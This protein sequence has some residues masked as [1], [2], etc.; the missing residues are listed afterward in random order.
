V[1][2]AGRPHSRRARASWAGPVPV[3]SLRFLG[4]PTLRVPAPAP[5][6]APAGARAL[7]EESGGSAGRRGGPPPPAPSASPLSAS[8]GWICVGGDAVAALTA[9]PAR[10]TAREAGPQA[11][12]NAANAAAATAAGPGVGG[13]WAGPAGRGRGR[14]PEPSACSVRLRLR[15]GGAMCDYHGEESLS[16]GLAEEALLPPGRPVV[17]PPPRASPRGTRPPP[18]RGPRHPHL[19]APRRSR[20]RGP[21]GFAG[22]APPSAARGRGGTWGDPAPSPRVLPSARVPA[23]VGEGRWRVT[24]TIVTV[25]CTRGSHTPRSG[26]R[27]APSPS[28]WCHRCRD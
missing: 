3:K 25:V 11:A 4:A 15:R 9:V 28:G 22:T 12:A 13:E 10:R 24:H 2:S 17:S 21:S 23:S 19:A 1:Q 18:R 14:G 7:G 16:G 5:A 6:P 27:L 20:R 26:V 8:C